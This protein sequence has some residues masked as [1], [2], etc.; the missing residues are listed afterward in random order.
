MNWQTGV[1]FGGM[2]AAIALTG[3]LLRPGD[4]ALEAAYEK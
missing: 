4:S 2:P 3:L 1:Y